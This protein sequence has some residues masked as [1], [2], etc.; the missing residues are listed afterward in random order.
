MI[1][2][3][4]EK[5]KI[6]DEILQ[7][8]NEILKYRTPGEV[9][10]KAPDLINQYIKLVKNTNAYIPLS[11]E[12]SPILLRILSIFYGR[13][14]S[15]VYFLRD[16]IVTYHPLALVKLINRRYFIVIQRIRAQPHEELVGWRNI[17]NANFSIGFNTFPE[18]ALF[19]D[20]PRINSVHVVIRLPKG[21]RIRKRE[22]T[23]KIY[24]KMSNKPIED[25]RRDVGVIMLDTSAGKNDKESTQAYCYID[26]QA[27]MMIIRKKL[28]KEREELEKLLELERKK[29]SNQSPERR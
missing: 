15:L 12:V 8:I 6:R 17:L 29:G 23:L 16:E 7:T 18:L 25:I 24:D 1:I 4:D 3:E 9:S 22:L 26:S 19:P 20:G 5:G 10:K 13:V 14:W 27:L 11:Y 2:D 21:V 28:E